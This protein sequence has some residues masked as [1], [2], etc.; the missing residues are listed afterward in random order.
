MRFIVSSI[1]AAIA[2]V[3]PAS[4][5]LPRHPD[6]PARESQIGE[7]A[8]SVSIPLNDGT[9]LAADLYLPDSAGPHPVILE[10][11]P[12]GQGMVTRLSW[13]MLAAP[14]PA[15]ERTLLW[16]TPDAT[17]L[18]LSNGL[19]PSAGRAEKSVCAAAPTAAPTQSRRQLVGRGGLPVLAP[20]QTSRADLTAPLSLAVPLCKAGPWAGRRT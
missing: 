4:T 16:Q 19:R 17:G 10:V 7:G 20:M 11:T 18:R 14:G 2:F 1:A 15:K 5:E 6:A 3:G 9:T 13:L 12:Y 8:Q